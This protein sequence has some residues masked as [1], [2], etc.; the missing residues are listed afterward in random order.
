MFKEQLYYLNGRSLL[1]IWKIHCIE[2]PHSQKD[3]ISLTTL[4][5]VVDWEEFWRAVSPGS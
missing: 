1:F 3:Y 4:Y 5:K 2:T